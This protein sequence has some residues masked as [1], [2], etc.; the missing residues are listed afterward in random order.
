MNRRHWLIGAT[1]AAALLGSANLAC[2][3]SNTIRIIFPYAAGGTGDATVRL[4]ADKMSTALNQPVV[5]ENRTGGAGRIGVSAVKNAEPDGLTL[6]FTPF[7]A[8]T[9]YPFVYRTLDYDPFKDLRPLS[10]INTFDFGI[11][12]NNDVP[13]KNPKE[14]VAWLKANPRKAQFGSPGAGALP[15]FFGLM[16]GKA[17]G[18]EMTHIA[19]KGG[20]P[21]IADLLGG[22]IPIVSST[23]SEFIQLHQEKKLRVIGT[24]DVERSIGLQDVPTFKESGI[25]IV[26]T[27][28]YAMFAPA[29]TPDATIARLNKV[30]VEAVKSPDFRKRQLEW[31]LNPTGTSPEELGR[32]QKADAERWAPVVKASGFVAD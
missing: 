1:A 14:L 28:W 26:G 10:Q 16:F 18:I 25:D 21:A 5:V 2:A 12:V 19:Y 23:A 7:A 27:S 11:A 6:L 22:Q 24:S 4:L 3:Q 9:I 31:G 32:I 29:K 20:T 8:V 30:I 13:A 15:H 17:A